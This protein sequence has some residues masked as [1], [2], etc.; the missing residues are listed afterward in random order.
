L[1]PLT[2][3]FRKLASLLKSIMEESKFD[4]CWQLCPKAL[5]W[6]LIL[7]G[8]AAS[9]TADRTWYVQNLSAVS[10]A[11]N[12]VEWED[13]VA[14]LGSYLWLECACDPG[15]RGLWT[16]VQHDRLLVEVFEGSESG[17]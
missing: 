10:S 2:G 17:S 16:E 5:L 1:P 3:I 14:E 6:I 13:V 8:I 7:G 15:G 11:L 12:L 9:D 4:P